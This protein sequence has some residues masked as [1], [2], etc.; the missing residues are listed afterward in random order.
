[1]FWLLSIAVALVR[2]MGDRTRAKVVVKMTVYGPVPAAV[3]D[4]MVR[5]TEAPRLEDG[6]L[7]SERKLISDQDGM[8]G[9]AA[10]A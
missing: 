6:R 1:M 2:C 4:P 3:L 9:R 5:S 7:P 8:A 10:A